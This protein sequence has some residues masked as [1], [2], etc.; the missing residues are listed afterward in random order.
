MAADSGGRQTVLVADLH[1]GVGTD[2][3]TGDWHA[4]EDARWG[5][6][7]ARF[8]EAIETEGD[9]ATDLVLN[10]DTFELWQSTTTD[11]APGD[12]ALGCTEAEAVARL[13]RVISAHAVEIAA[14]GRFA[15]AGSNRV[16]LVPGD[17][18]AAL[19][20]PSVAR[21]ATDAIDAPDGRVQ[22]VTAGAWQSDD[23]LI[24]AE[25]GH[26]IGADPA[27]LEGWP[28]PFVERDGV[29]YLARSWEERAV[30]ALYNAR[31]AE[32]PIVDNVAQVGLGVKYLLVSDE[33]ANMAIST[34][35]LL[36]YFLFKMP[37]AQYRSNLEEEVQPPEWDLDQIRRTQGDAFL[38]ESLPADD[39]FHDH[40]AAVLE[41]GRLDLSLGDLS[42]AELVAI[43]DHRAVLRRARRRLEQT[44]TQLAKTPGPAPRE[45]PRQ[46][47]TL[48]GV[49]SEF[50]RARD[51]A[52]GRY[53]D[54]VRQ[55]L[56]ATRDTGEPF[57][58]FV[59]S[60]THLP[61]RGF[62]PTRGAW[63]PRVVNTGAW[64]RVIYPRDL[65]QRRAEREIAEADVLQMI[66]P[67]D[68]PPCYAFVQVEPYTTAP[69]PSLRF[70]R[71][72]EEG[73]WGIA[74]ACHVGY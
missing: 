29:T 57:Q 45:C 53:L 26:Q 35:E 10:G 42:D 69:E 54:G 25:H 62:S 15:S 68:L 49:Y 34:G 23:A 19:L 7:L 12:D 60:H 5:E 17:H 22:V 14:L 27:R 56:A 66:R 65:E 51:L 43:C 71:R 39:P 32:H 73:T 72:S 30:Q 33:F 64:Q 44:V 9:G 21:T 55:R 3:E 41:E 6:D 2:P 48:G 28:R 11:C 59:Y 38:V 46:E 1:L 24:Y 63:T 8:L 58:T 61:A 13:Q 4:L 52:F 20:L 31:E 47:H 70:W 16:F 50:F 37:W 40:A 18:D 36:R 74:G 67:E